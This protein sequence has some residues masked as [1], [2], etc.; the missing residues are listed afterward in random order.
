M[1]SRIGGAVQRLYEAAQ[2]FWTEVR[3]RAIAAPDA[4]NGPCFSE[5]G[6][7]GALVAA[8]ANRGRQLG[9]LPVS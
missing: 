8:E 5:A 6:E 7:R 4:W 9:E 2:R 1:G 3:I